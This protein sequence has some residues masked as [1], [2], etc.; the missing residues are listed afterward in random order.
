[1][2]AYRAVGLVSLLCAIIVGHLGYI[3]GVT[4]DQVASYC[5]LVC[6]LK[7]IAKISCPSCGLT[8]GII[9][10]LLLDFKA[11]WNFHPLSFLIF[12]IFI[13]ATIQAIFFPRHCLASVYKTT[14]FLKANKIHVFFFLSIY[15]MWGFFLR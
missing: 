8:R 2:I 14:D 11:A 12:T 9:S 6:P 13:G 3:L 10:I 5:P 4:V 7:L 15:T 1:M